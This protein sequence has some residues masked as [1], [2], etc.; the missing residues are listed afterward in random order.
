MWIIFVVIVIIV[1]FWLICFL[2]QND[3]QVMSFKLQKY[4]NVLVIYPHPDDEVLTVGGFMSKMSGIGGRTTLAVLTKGDKGES[5]VLIPG[6]Q[7]LGS[8]RETEL[9]DVCENT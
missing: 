6:G 4:K 1:V 7:T 9:K 8:I 2:Y 5:S 3:F